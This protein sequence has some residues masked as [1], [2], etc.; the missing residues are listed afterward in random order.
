MKSIVKVILGVY[1]FLGVLMLGVMLVV[2]VIEVSYVVEHSSEWVLYILS[3]L[4]IA[5]IISYLIL[6]KFWSKR[7]E[8]DSQIDSEI[9]LLRKQIEQEKLQKELNKLRE[10]TNPKSKRGKL[11]QSA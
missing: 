4:A 2:W 1:S 10:D 8:S 11:A 5:T 7:T 3:F 6:T 9:N